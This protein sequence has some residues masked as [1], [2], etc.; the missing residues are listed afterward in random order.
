MRAFI[1]K[2]AIDDWKTESMSMSLHLSERST[3]RRI[4]QQRKKESKV[5]LNTIEVKTSW[6]SSTCRTNIAEVEVCNCLPSIGKS[7]LCW[8]IPSIMFSNI[9]YWE[10]RGRSHPQRKAVPVP[11]KRV[12]VRRQIIQ[13][14]IL[15]FLLRHLFL[16]TASLLPT[17][18]PFT[19]ICL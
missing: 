11:S 10:T 4:L 6:N 19:K 8:P 12:R 13:K 17:F 14:I 1:W 18:S 2:D 7:H 15:F 5:W 3:L 16:I 9:D